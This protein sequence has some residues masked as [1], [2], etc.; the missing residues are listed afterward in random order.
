MS[1]EVKVRIRDSILDI[2]EGIAETIVVLNEKGY[3]MFSSSSKCKLLLKSFKTC[4][5]P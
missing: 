4:N 3:M 5:L 1:S 2:D